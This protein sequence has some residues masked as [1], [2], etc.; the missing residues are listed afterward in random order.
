MGLTG[1]FFDL[2]T[3]GKSHAQQVGGLQEKNAIT[4]LSDARS[5]HWNFSAS[6]CMFF[7]RNVYVL[8]PKVKESIKNPTS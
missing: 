1:S 8:I 7:F 2:I 4:M 6:V 3:S 5:G